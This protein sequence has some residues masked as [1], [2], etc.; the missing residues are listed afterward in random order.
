MLFVLFLIFVFSKSEVYNST[1]IMQKLIIIYEKIECDC[2]EEPKWQ[3]LFLKSDMI[4]T[5]CPLTQWLD[6]ACECEILPLYLGECQ[7][8]CIEA[9][10][11]GHLS[12]DTAVCSGH[13]VCTRTN[14]C[15]CLP[16]YSGKSCQL[17]E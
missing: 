2:Y 15:L 4:H 1:Q 16:Q 10:C 17:T 7:C 14:K 12:S 9:D 3:E 6:P 8:D 5:I 11:Y 13:G